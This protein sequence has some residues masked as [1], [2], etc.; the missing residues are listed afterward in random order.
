MDYCILILEKILKGIAGKNRVNW[1]EIIKNSGTIETKI[2]VTKATESAEEE[3]H[4]MHMIT[5]DLLIIVLCLDVMKFKLHE[6]K[7]KQG[8]D[9]FDYIWV[10][11][12]SLTIYFPIIEEQLKKIKKRQDY[13]STHSIEEESDAITG[14]IRFK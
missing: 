8:Q 13:Y 11:R 12:K 3:S 9:L 1:E 14:K 7:G 10:L 5:G 4:T 2:E 6:I